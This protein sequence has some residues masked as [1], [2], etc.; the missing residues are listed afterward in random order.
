MV[1]V[2]LYAS[3]YLNSLEVETT[4]RFVVALKSG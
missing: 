1:F 4:N 2:E 3:M